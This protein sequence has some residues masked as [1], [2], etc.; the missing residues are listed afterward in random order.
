MLAV[1]SYE[2][3]G[4]WGIYVGPANRA[5]ESGPIKY[6]LRTLWRLRGQG[7]PDNV[8][9]ATLSLSPDLNYNSCRP[10]WSCEGPPSNPYIITSPQSTPRLH[11]IRSLVSARLQSSPASHPSPFPVPIAHD[12]Y[13][14][15]TLCN[16]S[17]PGELC[18]RKGS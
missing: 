3:T 17:H 5:I 6:L 1:S 9:R 7:L 12:K 11:R 13:S 8:V 18:R 15:A 4:E 14:T 2:T 10:L 16:T